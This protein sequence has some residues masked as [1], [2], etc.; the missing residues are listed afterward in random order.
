MSQQ[1]GTEDCQ[2][3]CHRWWKRETSSIARKLGVLRGAIAS[4]SAVV[5]T[6]N[7]KLCSRMRTLF[8]RRL[9]DWAPGTRQHLVSKKKFLGFNAPLHLSARHVWN[10]ALRTEAIL[11]DHFYDSTAEKVRSCYWQGVRAHIIYL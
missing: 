4:N 7:L 6:S 10:D 1:Q 2:R 11:Q 9:L 3:H 8:V 5:S